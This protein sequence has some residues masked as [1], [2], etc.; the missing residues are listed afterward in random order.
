MR[1]TNIA[2]SRKSIQFVVLDLDLVPKGSFKSKPLEIPDDKAWVVS[3]QSGKEIRRQS[4]DDFNIGDIQ[5]LRKAKTFEEP[6]RRKIYPAGEEK[7]PE[8]YYEAGEILEHVEVRNTDYLFIQLGNFEEINEAQK[9]WPKNEGEEWTRNNTCF[10]LSDEGEIIIK[11]D[12]VD[13]DCSRENMEVS[14]HNDILNLDINKLSRGNYEF[15][16]LSGPEEDS[17]VR[18]S[19]FELTDDFET[20]L[21]KVPYGDCGMAVTSVDEDGTP[22]ISF[23]Q[24]IRFDTL[25]LRFTLK[26][27][28]NIGAE[29]TM[30]PRNFNVE[31]KEFEH[32]EEVRTD[33]GKRFELMLFQDDNFSIK[34]DRENLMVG[35]KI[36]VAVYLV[37]ENLKGVKF[38]VERC[39][40][41]NSEG[42]SYDVIKGIYHQER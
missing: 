29:V 25:D 40:M 35:E 31:S 37:Q 28:C 24:T 2:F 12:C 13:V 42:M 33:W 9:D 32:E 16:I 14:L 5:V 18:L 36:N 11:D 6:V 41:T 21:V 23:K 38:Y 17:C 26:A 4:I 3:Y 8:R 39:Y 20:S 7:E 15:E 19:S 22:M 27:Q 1:Q 30:E 34:V 10:Y